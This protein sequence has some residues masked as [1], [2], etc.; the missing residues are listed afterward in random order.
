MPARFREVLHAMKACGVT[1]YQRAGK[2]SHVVLSDGHGNAYA[3]SLHNGDRSMLS[4]VYLRGICRT[5]GID[6]A[7]FRSKL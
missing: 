6:F 4:D 3:L 1:A 7:T 2:G 5:F